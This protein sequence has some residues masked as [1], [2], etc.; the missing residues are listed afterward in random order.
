MILALFA[1]PK[2][3]RQRFISEVGMFINYWCHISLGCG[4]PKI[5]E[6]GQFFIE[7]FKN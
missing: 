4:V 6:I 2:V 7:L 1:L 5:T 3:V